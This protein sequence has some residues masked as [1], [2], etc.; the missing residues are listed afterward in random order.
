MEVKYAVSYVYDNIILH[1]HIADIEL[2]LSN[3][4]EYG[5]KDNIILGNIKY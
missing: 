1:E 2:I 3:L 5:F 4:S